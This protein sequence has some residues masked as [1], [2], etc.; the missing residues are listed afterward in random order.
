MADLRGIRVPGAD[1]SNSICQGTRFEG[2]DLRRVNFSQSWLSAA[3]FTGAILAE[4]QFGGRFTLSPFPQFPRLDTLFQPVQREISSCCYSPDGKWLALGNSKGN[5]LIYE[6]DNYQKMIVFK[7]W[8]LWVN[9]LKNNPVNQLAFNGKSDRLIAA[10]EDCCLRLWDILSQ[11]LIWTFKCCQL[12]DPEGF[13]YDG[14][15]HSILVAFHPKNEQFIYTT[16]KDATIVDLCDAN[17][18]KRLHIFKCFRD[19]ETL[20]IVYRPD[21]NQLALVNSK[22]VGLWNTLTNELNI[23]YCKKRVF[24]KSLLVMIANN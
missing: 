8:S 3:N 20:Q 24:I 1:L 4:V 17:T 15:Y 10:S 16:S 13:H 12:V 11:N 23:N 2:A 9:H 14:H 22:G 6:T 21:G 5:L 18:K 19:S 7:N